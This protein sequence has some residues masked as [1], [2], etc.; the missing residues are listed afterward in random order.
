MKVKLWKP[1]LIMVAL[2]IFSTTIP[3]AF[4]QCGLPGKLAKPTN[5]NSSYAGARLLRAAFE[6]HDDDEDGGP[7]IV[8]MWHVIFTAHTQN[9]SPIKD[10]V[11]DNAIAVWHKDGTEI[12]NSSRPAQD[13]NFCLGV[14]EKTGRFKYRLNHIP[15]GGN[16]PENAPGGIGYPSAGSQIIE[17]VILHPDGDHFSGTFTL[18]A[19]TDKGQPA[20]SFTGFLAATRITV[21]TP[22]TS[23]F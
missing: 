9:G 7:S 8:G 19:Y 1:S 13:G 10:Q 6:K 21:N 12:M 23:L 5:W 3:N 4:A 22:I 11:I 2:A 14:W 20:V 15:W 16:D 18:T 17:N